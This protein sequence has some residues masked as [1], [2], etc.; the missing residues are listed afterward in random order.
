MEAQSIDERELMN[1]FI[2]GSLAANAAVLA[3]K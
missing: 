1:V 2:D 3:P